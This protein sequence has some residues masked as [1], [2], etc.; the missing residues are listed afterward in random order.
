MRKSVPAAAVLLLASCSQ[1]PEQRQSSE[2]LKTFD[3]AEQMA[4]PSSPS[5]VPGAPPPM[6]TVA[7]APITRT[8]PGEIGAGPNIGV[9]AAPGVAFNYRYAYRLPN[10][11]IQVAQEAHAAMC[12]KLTI[13]RCRITGMRY[14]LVNERDISASLEVKL[15]PAIARAFGKDATKVVTDAQGMLVDQQISGIDVGTTIDLADR[16]RAQ[17][18]DE[19]DR[20]TRELARPGLSNVIRDR[21]LSEAQSLRSQ[22]RALGEQKKAGEEALATTPMAF[23][24]GSGRAVPGFDEATP[25]RDA[26]RRAGYNFLSALGAIIE[27]IAALL[28]IAAILALAWWLFRRAQRR[29]GWGSGASGYRDNDR[30]AAPP[31]QA[32]HPPRRPRKP[33]D[34]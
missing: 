24:Y 32:P 6:P 28:P 1:Q 29:F 7:P 10:A 4:P 8:P 2:D 30:A 33:V 14:A 11:R 3:T 16:G 18:Q 20:V 34:A 31:P 15:D 5:A 26:V 21:L 13:T 17:L 9:T 19:L 12:E 22:I 25:L 23:Y 27:V